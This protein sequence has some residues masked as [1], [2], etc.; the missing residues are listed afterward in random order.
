MSLALATSVDLVQLATAIFE[1][2]ATSVD[3]VVQAIKKFTGATSTSTSSTSKPKRA[4][5]PKKDADFELALIRFSNNEKRMSCSLVGKK[6]ENGDLDSL[7]STLKKD[8]KE[9][10]ITERKADKTSGKHF[11]FKKE[12]IN[13]VIAALEEAQIEFELLDDFPTKEV[14]GWA[15]FQREAKTLYPTEFDWDN[16]EGVDH[17]EHFKA[18][19]HFIS[20]KWN[21]DP[22]A[23][24]T[25]GK[26]ASK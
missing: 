1:A 8:L 19:S 3:E 11:D 5:G 2:Q 17:K 20:S 14:H 9:A 22:V 13:E 4:S 25:Y 21:S 15:L 24:T 6:V 12:S 7:M 23:Q 10:K 26:K 16:T 18:R